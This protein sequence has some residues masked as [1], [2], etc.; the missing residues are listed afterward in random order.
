MDSKFLKNQIL[1]FCRKEQ[2]CKKKKL[3]KSIIVL[4][5]QTKTT[6]SLFS[7]LLNVKSRLILIQKIVLIHNPGDNFVRLFCYET[8]IFLSFLF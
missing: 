4:L 7:L 2:F 1:W 8:E 6:F 5:W 3:Q